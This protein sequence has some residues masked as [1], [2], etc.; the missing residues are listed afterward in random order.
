MLLKAVHSA[1]HHGVSFLLS[2]FVSQNS[3]DQRKQLLSIDCIFT[4]ASCPCFDS[5]FM[6]GCQGTCTDRLCCSNAFTSITSERVSYAVTNSQPC[7]T[8]EVQIACRTCNSPLQ[9]LDPGSDGV[10]RQDLDEGTGGSQARS[11]LQ[12]SHQGE[13]RPGR[14]V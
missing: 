11:G 2:A 9:A 4:K 6:H 13:S 1:L 7:T 10:I 14:V 12:C 5:C 3:L 8:H